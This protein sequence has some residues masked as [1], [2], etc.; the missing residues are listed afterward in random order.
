MVGAVYW[1][2]GLGY[3]ECSEEYELTMTAILNTEPETEE[4]YAAQHRV[5]QLQGA[6][7]HLDE[8]I[9]FDKPDVLLALV[10]GGGT[11]VAPGGN[12]AIVWAE[13]QP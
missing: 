12:L 7:V 6:C 3:T 8:R 5:D 11:R 1:P 2:N 13:Q 4:H 10:G 9:T